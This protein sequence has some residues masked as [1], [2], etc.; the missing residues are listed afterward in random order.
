MNDSNQPKRIQ[1]E[2]TRDELVWLRNFLYEES[3]SAEI[4]HENVESLHTD[5]AIKAAKV[6]LNREQAQMEKIVEV[7]DKTTNIVA[8]HEALARKIAETLPEQPLVG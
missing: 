6:A 5:V 2:L 8:A 4:D 3:L 7:I 1:I